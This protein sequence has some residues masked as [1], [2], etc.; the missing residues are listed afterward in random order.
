M[1]SPRRVVLVV[2]EPP[3]VAHRVCLFLADIN[4]PVSTAL[5]AILPEGLLL[6]RSL[7]HR[8]AMLAT[9]L[10][11]RACSAPWSTMALVPIV[12]LRSQPRIAARAVSKLDERAAQ[13][14]RDRRHI[15]PTA[16]LAPQTIP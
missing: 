10:A 5:L 13:S 15:F 1:L 4:T 11:G 8:I 9:A 16:R 6:P 3:R 2:R 12:R 14:V 7:W